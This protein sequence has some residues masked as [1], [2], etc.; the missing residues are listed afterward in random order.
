VGDHGVKDPFLDTA[1]IDFEPF[2]NAWML[3]HEKAMTAAAWRRPATTSSSSPAN[4]RIPATVC[5]LLRPTCWV[6]Q[7]S[8]KTIRLYSGAK[9]RRLQSDAS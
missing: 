8:D 9:G 4:S 1:E 2:I 6:T 3:L 5:R 7:C